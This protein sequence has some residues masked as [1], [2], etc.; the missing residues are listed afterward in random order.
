MRRR[1]IALLLSLSFGQASAAGLSFANALQQAEA[2]AP[3]LKAGAARRDGARE[4]AAAADALPDPRAF[5]G[6]ENLPVEGADRFSLQRDG[7]TMQTVGVMQEF[8]NG[9]KR[10]AQAAIAQAEA[11]QEEASLTLTRNNVRRETAT[12]WLRRY[13]LQQQLEVLAALRQ[14]NQTLQQAVEAQVRSGRKRAADALLPRQERLVLEN[15]QDDIQRD[16]ALAD[17]SLRRWTGLVETPTLEGAAPRFDF[18]PDVWREHLQHHPELLR[19]R[20]EQD[21]ARAELQ[22]AT[23]GA[24]PDWGVELAY[25]HRGDAFGDMM[26]FQVSADLPLFS[27][28]RQTPRIRVRQQLLA[29]LEAEQESMRREHRERLEA[30]IATLTALERQ[31]E[32]L[33]KEAIPLAKEKV[34]LELSA[35]RAGNGELS[36]ALSA[37]Q[38]LRELEL[39]QL[40][41]QAQSQMLAASLHYLF[42]PQENRP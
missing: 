36:A 23:A 17:V 30:D 27:R 22:A 42:D 5:V 4:A 15:R 33:E 21:R 8:P 19:F 7:M 2:N 41:L 32:R 40:A 24:R 18:N 1:F 35:Y 20:P 37:R 39:Q 10:R 28:S 25:Q 16:I 34:A 14:D 38:E 13:Y 12:A 9:G 31:R 3:D 11:E 29:S 26:S 6:I